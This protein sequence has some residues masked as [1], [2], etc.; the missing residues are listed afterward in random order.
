MGKN[1]IIAGYRKKVNENYA[2]QLKSLFGDDVQIQSL[3]IGKPMVGEIKED[4]LVLIPSYDV[5]QSIED[6]LPSSANTLFIRS[7]LQTEGFKQVKKLLETNVVL[8]AGDSMELALQLIKTLLQLGVRRFKMKPVDLSNPEIFRNEVVLVAGIPQSEIPNARQVVDVKLPMLDMSTILDVGLK[9]PKK[10]LLTRKNIT[11]DY[12]PF[13]PLHH[14]IIWSLESSN[15]FNSSIK[16]LLSVIDGAVI[17]VTQN[18]RVRASNNRIESFFGISPSEAMGKSGSILFPQIPF[19]K[20]IDESKP[21]IES[22]IT[23][24]DETMIVTVKPVI[25]SGKYYGAIAVIKKFNDE[26]RR[27]H[28]LRTLSI[29]KGHCAKYKLDDIIGNS[30]V[31]NQCRSIA[32]RMANSNSSVLITGETGTGKEMFAQ[33]IHQASER[34]AYQFVAVNC[35]AIPESLLESELFGYEEGAFTG[36]RK[37]GKLGL[38]ELA[39][40]GTLFLD[41]I[42][43]MPILLQKRLLRVLQER[44]VIRLGGNSVIHVDVRIIAATNVN[45]Q[46]M[47]KKGNFREDLYYRLSV[48]PLM[49]PSLREREGDVR[50]LGEFFKRGLEGNFELTEEAWNELEQYRWPG[51]VREL[52]NYIEYFTNLSSTIVGVDE[53]SHMI[54]IQGCMV[55]EPLKIETAM[56]NGEFDIHEKSIFILNMLKEGLEKG[57]RLGRRSLSDSARKQGVFLGEQEIRKI[58]G[59]LEQQGLVE[60]RQNKA[61]TVITPKGLRLLQK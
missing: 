26:E 51:N 28:K 48:L 14:G 46:D 30:P 7:T 25:N 43:E 45:L 36:A 16:I 9:L 4:S 38:F 10:E 15:T 61:G 5:Y 47:I 55:S 50:L 60:I 40:K 56:E 53:L 17:S 49:I 31:M 8:V 39:H 29:G 42:S 27:Q 35:G 12:I 11:Q 32:R 6:Y 37:G 34:K 57:R 13:L 20:V 3:E 52:R 24:N 2:N 18:C 58:L 59:Q 19:Q 1:I 41:E 33:A 54:P 23:I 44:E 22:L 21:I